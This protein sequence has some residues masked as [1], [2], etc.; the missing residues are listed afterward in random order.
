MSGETR[1]A[2]ITGG[3]RGIGYAIAERLAQRGDHLAIA[4]NA[5][6]EVT[7]SV[8]EKLSSRFGVPVIPLVIDLRDAQSCAD[9]V[10]ATASEFGKLD[11]L[12]NNAG[13]N[14]RKSAA[15]S[16][17]AQW[18][19]LIDTNVNGTF[20][21]SHAAYSALSRSRGNVVNLGSTAGYIA[22]RGSAAYAVSKAAIGH[23]TRVLA[24]EWAPVGIRVNAVC[25]TIVPTDMTSD[26]LSDEVYMEEKLAS[27]PMG[28]VVLPADVA[29]A[30][31][32]LTSL[33]ARMITGQRLYVDG[34]A[35]LA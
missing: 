10:A 4:G 35:T 3:T 9:A 2:L 19:A 27:I 25:P 26:V 5:S 6:K 18:A 24:L 29:H 13:I 22:V 30:V 34:G 17:D 14:Y 1:A 15:E 8:A 28:E 20:R 33:E 16:D 12:V 32:W 21:M 23:L 31:A 11:I 7:R